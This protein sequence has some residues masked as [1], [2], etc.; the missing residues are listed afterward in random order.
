MLQTGLQPSPDRPDY[1][2]DAMKKVL[3]TGVYLWYTDINTA[4]V[5]NNFGMPLGLPNPEVSAG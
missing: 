5:S 4:D 2:N 3:E 1:A